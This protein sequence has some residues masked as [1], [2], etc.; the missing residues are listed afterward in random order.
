MKKITIKEV[1]KY[2]EVSPSTVS[3]VLSN[4]YRI[5]E[6]TQKKVRKAVKKLGYHPNAI[7]RS[8]VTQKTKTLGLILSRPA[9]EAF[10]NPFFP[11]I[12]QSIASISQEKGFSL[13]LASS[14]DY[15]KEHE[16]ALKMLRYGKV[17]G[18]ILM[19]S[20][21]NDDIVKQLINNNYPFVLV[22]RSL[23][24]NEIPIV[25]NDNIKA[26][27]QAV[28]FLINKGYEKI[29]FISGPQE[30]VVSQ[31]REKGYKKALK[32]YNP[33]LVRYSGF[34]YKGGY[35]QTQILL[36]EQEVDVI[37]SLDDMIASGALRAAQN[38]GYDV[39]RDIA[40]MGFNDD[41][42][43]AYLK[44]S[45]TTVRIPVV[46]MGEKAAEMLIRIITEKDYSGEEIIVSTE[47]IERESTPGI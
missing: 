1:A 20:R 28:K 43:A 42:M 10:A 33:A 9:E 31:D 3:R 13:L 24:L 8:L 32:E 23:E 26:S 30:Y 5:S 22:G 2:A 19:A 4:D 25:N 38:S 11:G 35:R 18:V 7:A 47:I 40:I 21:V 6:E 36:G 46:K 34:S 44:P 14:R 37:L 39:P 45:L 15:H 41:P 16:E 17:D 29:A 27:Y 12:L